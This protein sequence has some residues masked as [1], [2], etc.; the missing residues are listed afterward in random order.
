M[1]ERENAES[2]RRVVAE[3]ITIGD[4]ITTGAI[5]DTN[6]S[7]LSR[8]LADVGARV[9]RRITVGDNLNEIVAAVAVAMRRAD[10]VVC[11]GGLGATQDD[12]TRQAAAIALG[13][14]LRFDQTSYDVLRERF[15]LQ[16]NRSSEFLKIQSFF[17]DGSRAIANPNGTAP[18]FMFEGKRSRLPDVAVP[19]ETLDC[20]NRV[21][22][23]FFLASFPGVPAELREM[24]KEKE[25]RGALE[26]FI[27]RIMGGARMV[28]R[29]KNLHLFGVGENEIETRLPSLID[30]NHFPTVGITA[31]DSVI[32]LRIFAE[33]LSEDDCDK[34]I[35]EISRDVFSKV[36]EYVF[37]EDEETLAGALGANLRPQCRKVG[38]FEWGTRGLLAAALDS[39]VLG[40]GRIFGDSERDLFA[41]LF[42]VS[43]QTP[44]NQR[45]RR[46]NQGAFEADFYVDAIPVGR[47]LQELY[48]AERRG[49]VVDYLLAVGPYPVSSEDADAKSESVDV[50]FVDFRDPK[51]PVMR[52]ETFAFRGHPAVI[53]A[54]FCNRAMDVLLRNQ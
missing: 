9:K 6:A 51:I 28:F 14:D 20:G 52:R 27:H 10:V 17:P 40:F 33:G 21:K 37:G 50:V 12:L 46:A 4:E 43:S 42:G 31:K 53:D 8:A 36:G 44:E 34:Q 49:A 7:F 23:E 32:T 22:G 29:T 54:L 19:G 41:R 48:D 1:T 13:V 39:D 38:T 30:R 11:T 26:N 2:K 45:K 5:L 47:E 18:G 24:W 25:T 35:D 15:A 16:R 3:I